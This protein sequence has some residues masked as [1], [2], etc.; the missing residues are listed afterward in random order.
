MNLF[1]RIKMAISPNK[2][3]QQL[4]R[5]IGMNTPLAIEQNSDSYIRNGYNANALVYSVVSQIASS[6]ADSMKYAKIVDANGEEV[7]DPKL[8]NLLN[9]PN[10]MQG[11][12][13]F[14]QQLFGFKLITG[15][16]YTYG[17]K[18]DAG[19]NKG[20]I[21]EL[22][23]MPSQWT[24]IVSGGS[25]MPVKGYRI[26][27]GEQGIEYD[28]DEV[29]HTKYPNYDYDWGQ[30]LYGMSPLRA[31]AR[32]VSK[33]NEAYIASQKSFENMG[34]I[35]IVAN[36][37]APNTT[38]EFTEEQAQSIERSWTRKYGGSSKRG[39]LAFTSARVKFIDMGLSPVDLGVIDDQKWNLQD[40]CRI[41]HVPSILFND[42]DTAT[43]NNYE[44]ARRA[45]YTQAIQPLVNSWI[46]EFNRWIEKAY[47]V[48]VEIDWDKI[49]EL[50][51]DKKLQAE[52]WRIAVQEGAMSL[53]EFREKLGLKPSGNPDLDQY[54]V[55][56]G[57]M[58]LGFELNPDV[59]NDYA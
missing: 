9:R 25:L 43:Y 24:E 37:S 22:W 48:K 38:S 27:I 51:K 18:L 54:M 3:V 52:T 49:P 16:D 30:D 36:D 8:L 34:A 7:N 1:D 29:L 42:N 35:G 55:N 14:F 20:K 41:Y 45:F 17:V 26:T 13:E 21:Q 31:A 50:Q 56:A 33:S 6:A 47:N 19:Q 2:L 4:Y 39:K 5:Y 10:P 59:P 28:S 53:E 57:R 46:E 15:N 12:I 23:V 58:P 44:T 32:V 40:I 11:R